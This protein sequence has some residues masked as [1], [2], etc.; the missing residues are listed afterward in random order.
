MIPKNHILGSPFPSLEAPNTEV[1]ALLPLLAG[2]APAQADSSIPEELRKFG[3]TV[4]EKVQA[5]VKGIKEID[6]SKTWL[7]PFPGCGRT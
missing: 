6:F 7:G 4:K 3:D 2:P 1:V 5:A